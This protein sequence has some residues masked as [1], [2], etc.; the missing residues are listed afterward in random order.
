MAA[1]WWLGG[2]STVYAPICPCRCGWDPVGRDPL[3]GNRP[4][5]F[6]EQLN[7]TFSYLVQLRATEYLLEHHAEAAPFVL[8]LG[9]ISGHD[10]VSSN[11]QVVAEVFAAVTP[12]NNDKLDK[13]VAK[14]ATS[15]A[16][17]KY[18]FYFCPGHPKGM[19]DR[20]G[21]KI[22]SLVQI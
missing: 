10:I 4:L 18:V 3:N 13:D 22:I 11:G 16:Q 12:D 6:T 21:V 5:N 17:H 20:G 15:E 9:P 8:S 19:K 14:V 1:A 2:H 7:Q